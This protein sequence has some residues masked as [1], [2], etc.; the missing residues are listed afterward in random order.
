MSVAEL[1]KLAMGEEKPSN[2]N[3]EEIDVSLNYLNLQETAKRKN[4]PQVGR[5][6]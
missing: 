2:D 1:V 5:N 4:G 3:N 6:M